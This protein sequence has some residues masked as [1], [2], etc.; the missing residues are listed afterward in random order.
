MYI[1]LIAT[2]HVSSSAPTRIPALA[3]SSL[4]QAW[5][6]R[7]GY[8]GLEVVK[9]PF[10]LFLAANS[11]VLPQC[12]KISCTESRQ[13]IMSVRPHVW[14]SHESSATFMALGAHVAQRVIQC[15]QCPYLLCSCCPCTLASLPPVIIPSCTYMLLPTGLQKK[16][17]C[18]NAVVTRVLCC[19]AAGLSGHQ[20]RRVDYARSSRSLE[21]FCSSTNE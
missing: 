9:Y 18:C 20:N 6:P 21:F 15:G 3:C 13:M 12:C 7:S 16:H 14:T 19:T 5:Q 1:Q 10:D 4:R 8:Q 2:F 11:P 17:R